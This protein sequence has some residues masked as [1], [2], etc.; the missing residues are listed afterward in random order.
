MSLENIYFM[1]KANLTTL[2]DEVLVNK[3]YMIRGQ[4][5]MLDRDLAELYGVETKQ[6]K[7]QVKRNLERFPEDFMFELTREEYNSLRSQIGT[8]KKGEHS[9]FLP[10]VFTEHGVLMLSSVLNSQKAIQVNIQIMRVFTHI[11][12]SLTD[13]TELRLIIE[14]IRKKTDNNTKNIEVVFQYFDELLDK[15]EKV[16]PRTQIGYKIGK[17]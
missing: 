3:I 12:Q 1:E 6:L 11:R 7:R 13:N 17:K 4:K 9:K 15:K 5:V 16:E 14:E 10:M 2:P 8:L